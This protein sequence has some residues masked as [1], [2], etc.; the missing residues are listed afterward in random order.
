MGA[1]RAFHAL[2]LKVPRKADHKKTYGQSVVAQFARDSGL[3]EDT[4]RKARA[5]ADPVGGY[6]PAELDE[7]CDEITDAGSR[8]AD[9]DFSVFRVSHLI[10]LLSV[11]PKRRRKA[12]Q[13]RAVGE[14]WSTSRLE[15]E[16]ARVFGTRRA[17]GRKPAVPRTLEEW[18]A[19]AER[20]CE[21]WRRWS[22]TLGRESAG[23]HVRRADL[24]PAVGKAFR[25]AT[26]G[27]GSLQLAVL[28][29]LGR[30]SPDRAQRVVTV[31]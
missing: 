17:G 1:I 27:V 6:T 2:G 10:R 29:E 5:F 26:A 8:H 13:G 11:G 20:T 25:A 12:M 28:K 30:R 22:A 31:E 23:K 19:L 7:L 15:A 9:S 4:V 3:N 16:I 14:G 21:S 24:P 18:L